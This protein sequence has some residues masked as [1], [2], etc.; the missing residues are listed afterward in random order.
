MLANYGFA[1]V[2]ERLGHA[3]SQITLDVYSDSM[4]NDEATLPDCGTKPRETS[5]RDP[6]YCLQ[7]QV[8]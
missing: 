4:K 3:N 8:P 2:N 6:E 5:S 7:Y 1:A